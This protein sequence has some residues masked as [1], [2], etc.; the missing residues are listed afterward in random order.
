MPAS[1]TG[2]S[3]LVIGGGVLGSAVAASVA[4]RGHDV[5]LVTD[6]PGLA[7]RV[8][9][10]SFAWVNTAGSLPDDYRELRSDARAVHADLSANGDAWFAQTGSEV[11]TERT[12]EDGW[13]DVARFVAAQRA[14]VVAR[15][16]SVRT[17]VRVR[18]LRRTS[19]GL[20]ATAVPLGGAE[21]Q[22]VAELRPDRVVVAAGTGTAELLR[23]LGPVSRR[24]GTATG[25]RGF[26]ARVRL[27]EPLPVDG[28]VVRDDLQL[29]PDGPGRL[30]VQSLR[31]EEALRAGGESAT[32]ATVWPHLRADLERA[33]GTDVP[34][35]ALL[36]VDEAARP[37]STDGL[38][39]VGPVE[40]DVHVVL[41]HSGV[42]LA[43]LLAEL[44]ARDL[45]GDAD[46]GARLRPYRP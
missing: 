37:V 7:T 42:T 38:P 18:D 3:V 11:G 46:A 4:V 26:L 8:G 12:A 15:G 1:R 10:A 22:D 30:A 14:R 41:T 35:Q 40:A 16:G 6:E 23:G 43:P 17:G 25:P 33:L 9:L 31:L 32:P 19:R 24:V 21:G 27:A 36:R 2:R 5:T 20:T 44:V 29:R 39:V 34:E 45:D 13:V 28:V